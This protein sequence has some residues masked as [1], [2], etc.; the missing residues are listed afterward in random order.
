M[1]QPERRKNRRFSLH[2]PATL[3]YGDGGLR[4]LK[5]DI[6]NASLNGVFLLADELVPMGSQV[7]VM[8]LLQK[9]GLQNVILHA[10]G[11]VVRQGNRSA[12][13]SGI[14]IAFQGQLN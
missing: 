8:L 5:A 2:Q 3:R 4:E 13:K 14:A 1:E 7:E 12:G 6:L 10:T 11:T 9:Q